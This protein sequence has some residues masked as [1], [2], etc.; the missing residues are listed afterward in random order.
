L[1]RGK[2]NDGHFHLQVTA[3]DDPSGNADALLFQMIPDIDLVKQILD[4]QTADSV[5]ITLRGCAETKG[6]RDQP[7]HNPAQR[8]IDLSPF[9]RDEFG[10]RR[11]FVNLAISSSEVRLWDAMDAATNTL[12]RKLA[13]DDPSAIQFVSFNRDGL[14]TTYHEAGTLWMGDDQATSVTTADGRFQHI[15]NAYCIDQA[16]FVTVG[17]VN[18]TLTGLTLARKVAEHLTS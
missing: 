11:A 10:F 18:P 6:T 4:A 1:V 7:I 13:N 2:T 3:A 15:S 17:S 5:T 8:W 16:L 12:A 14:G 9:E